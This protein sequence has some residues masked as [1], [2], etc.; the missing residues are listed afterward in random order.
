MNATAVSV[1]ALTALVL[2]TAPAAAQDGAAVFQARCATCH[3]SN[4]D[5][6]VPTVASLRQRAPE[7][8]VEALATGVMRQQASELT[9]AER[10]AVAEYLAGRPIA[11]AS[12]ADPA[13]GRCTMPQRF[14]AAAG[15]PWGS[16]GPAPSNTRFQPTPGFTAEQVPQL[17]LK[18]AFGFA[19]ASGMRALPTLAGGRVY[20]GSQSG[21]VYALDAKSGCVVW[22]F[23]AKAGVRSPVVIGPGRANIPAVAYFG[24]GRSNVYALNADTGA[25]LWSRPVEDHPNSHVTGAPALDG[26]RLYVPVSSGEEGQGNN[27][28]YECCTFRGS[29]VALDARTGALVWKT[30]HHRERATA[31]RE[32]SLGYDAV[33]PFW[34][35]HLGVANRRHEARAALRGHGQHVHGTSAGNCRRSDCLPACHRRDCLEL[36]VDA[37]GRVRRRLQPAQRRQLRRRCG[38]RLRLRE[39]ADAG[40]AR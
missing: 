19:G 3:T 21:A 23:Q 7:S 10:R 15:V 17:E 12:P 28:K 30:L 9:A 16:W 1:A 36:A 4:P 2:A 32:E 38:T 40:D 8:I 25:Q 39:R 11:A 33:G 14:D 13:V 22:T 31:A 18:W 34:S 20:I 24:D 29:I 6:R 5:T 35:G 27:A 37:E 26:N